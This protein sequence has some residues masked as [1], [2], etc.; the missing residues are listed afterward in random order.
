MGLASELKK[1]ACPSCG[2]TGTL[3]EIIYGMPNGDFDF[4]K[5]IVGGCLVG[6]DFPDIGCAECGWRGM[7]MSVGVNRFSG[8]GEV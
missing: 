2:K 5:N 8:P 4:E 7:G 1:V 6:D 3:Q